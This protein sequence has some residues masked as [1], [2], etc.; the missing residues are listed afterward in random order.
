MNRQLL[1]AAVCTAVFTMAEAAYY[2]H[3]TFETLDGQKISVPAVSLSLTVS[4]SELTAGEH[5]FVLDD[6]KKMYFTTSDLP[7]GIERL[8]SAQPI[9]VE[10]V[11][12]LQGRRVLNG[13]M[14]QGVYVV[15]KSNGET[16][17]IA[18]K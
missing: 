18:V 10:S 17:K 3:L 4:G 2:T 13:Q 15:K 14:P 6:L 11:Y 16:H 12:D 7:T 1:A 8:S 5:K 9:G